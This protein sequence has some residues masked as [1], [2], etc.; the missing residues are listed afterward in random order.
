[1]SASLGKAKKL[2]VKFDFKQIDRRTNLMKCNLIAIGHEFI[3]IE[4]CDQKHRLAIVV[5]KL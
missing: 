2:I 3:F 1:M 4:K 5:R